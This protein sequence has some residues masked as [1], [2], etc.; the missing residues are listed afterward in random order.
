[1]IDQYFGLVFDCDTK[2][3]EAEEEAIKSKEHFLQYNCYIDKE[4][5]YL[6]SGLRN[7]RYCP[8]HAILMGHWSRKKTTLNIFSLQRL[9]ETI[10][11]HSPTLDRD[12]EYVKSLKVSRLPAYLTVQMVRFQFKQK[13]AI[14]AKIL[15]D[16]KFPLLLDTFDL[17]SEE[18]QKKL[19]PMRTKFK[20]HFHLQNPFPRDCICY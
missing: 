6:H 3:V 8:I 4:V 9:K 17:C 1:M 5:K 16:I 18:L 12:A 19:I 20:V 15:K 11:K 13:D 10:T 2:C 14:N 7:V